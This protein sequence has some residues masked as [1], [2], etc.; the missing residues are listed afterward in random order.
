MNKKKIKENTQ[1]E[2]VLLGLNKII[3][4]DKIFH[5]KN[6]FYQKNFTAEFGHFLVTNF[7][8]TFVTKK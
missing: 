7:L 1:S 4:S 8:K 5:S 2:S 6:Y 3:K